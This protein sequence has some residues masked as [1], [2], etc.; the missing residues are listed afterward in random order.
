[1]STLLRDVNHVRTT[2]D[3]VLDSVEMSNLVLAFTDSVRTRH[4]YEMFLNDWTRQKSSCP[5]SISVGKV[6]LLEYTPESFRPMISVFV[7]GIEGKATLVDEV[8]EEGY[9]PST[10]YSVNIR[11]AHSA[12]TNQFSKS[13]GL[14]VL[15]PGPLLLSGVELDLELTHQ[16]VWA[17]IS[18]EPR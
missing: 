9:M 6:E 7:N 3:I 1:M 4:H 5:D 18:Y 2:V 10:K 14:L 15:R 11:L 12:E 17:D 13:I 16:R 8:L